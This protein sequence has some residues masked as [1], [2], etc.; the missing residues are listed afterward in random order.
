MAHLSKKGD[1]AANQLPD[2]EEKLGKNCFVHVHN[3]VKL[4]NACNELRGM[5]TQC[6]S[7]KVDIVCGGGNQSWY[8][9]S[10]THK[11]ERTD[12]LGNSHPDLL[13][14][15]INTVARL[16]FH[17]T[18]KGQPLYDRVGVEYVDDNSYA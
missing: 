14:G 15:L 18:T 16:K 10:K 8:F 1:E 17:D 11:A 3:D 9:R 13:N 5:Y 6:L 4:G 2:V 7:H 12:A